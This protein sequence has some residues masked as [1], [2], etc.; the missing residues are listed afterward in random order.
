MLLTAR[1]RSAAGRRVC[2]RN[3][4]L[5]SRVTGVSSI[6]STIDLLAHAVA[7][8]LKELRAYTL[9]AV[10]RFV[11]QAGRP[12]PQRRRAFYNVVFRVPQVT[13]RA[14]LTSSSHRNAGSRASDRCCVGGCPPLFPQ[15]FDSSV[16]DT[17]AGT[18]SSRSSII[19]IGTVFA[20]VRSGC[21]AGFSCVAASPWLCVT[22]PTIA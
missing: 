21:R 22:L 8:I 4:L 11:Y 6:T 9:R 18:R 3:F 2:V 20:S 17:G 5:T 10:T 19:G 12:S 14:V 16:R 13:Y 15:R 7:G 1:M